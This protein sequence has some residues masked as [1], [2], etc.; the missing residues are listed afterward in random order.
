M[1]NVIIRQSALRLPIHL[2]KNLCVYLL[3]FF[4][5][6]ELF[7]ESHKFVLPPPPHVYLAPPIGGTPTGILSTL[8]A[9]ENYSP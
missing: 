3:P 5:Y 2:P 6:S 9:S 4:R 1:D 7:V 8:L